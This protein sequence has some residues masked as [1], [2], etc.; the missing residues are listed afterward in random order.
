MNFGKKE[1][2]NHYKLAM[3]F[4]NDFLLKTE[5][6]IAQII[7]LSDKH[8]INKAISFLEMNFASFKNN[9]TIINYLALGHSKIGSKSHSIYYRALAKMLEGD[10]KSAKRLAY[11]ALNIT[12]SNNELSLKLND[13]I[14]FA[15]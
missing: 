3:K 2:I 12:K 4:S 6:A 15:D 5:N 9:R 7:L 10:S 13:I 8:T 11:S 1:A 14:N